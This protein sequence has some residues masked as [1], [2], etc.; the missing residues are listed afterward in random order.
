MLTE[1]AAMGDNISRQTAVIAV[2]I[3]VFNCKEYLREAVDS[4]LRQPYQEISIVLVDDGSTDGSGKL[5]DELAKESNRVVVLHQQ[6]AMLGLSISFQ[7]A[8]ALI[9]LHFLTQMIVGRAISLMI[10]LPD[11][12]KADMS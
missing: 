10:T 2:V 4:V 11:C 5:C 8:T 12:Y 1:H 6:L 3:P 7:Q 9:I